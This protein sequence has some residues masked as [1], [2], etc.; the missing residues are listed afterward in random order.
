MLG[1]EKYTEVMSL[2]VV[3]YSL[4]KR[5]SRFDLLAAFFVPGIGQESGNLEAELGIL[6][7]NVASFRMRWSTERP[8]MI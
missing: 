8:K 2:R 1:K 7:D 5:A 3:V 4:W 6:R